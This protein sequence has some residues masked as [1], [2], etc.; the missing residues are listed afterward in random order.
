MNL[1]NKI[2]QRGTALVSN[3]LIVFLENSPETRSAARIMIKRGINK[4]IPLSTKS[5]LNLA[6]VGV[7]GSISFST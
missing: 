1:L 5:T 7:I 2:F 6:A 4:V 3:I